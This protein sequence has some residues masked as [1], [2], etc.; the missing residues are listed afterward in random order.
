MKRF[1][2]LLILIAILI[3]ASYS[4]DKERGEI[5]N[6]QLGNKN[7][8]LLVADERGEWEKGLM[9][10]KKLKTANGVIFIFPD[11][12]IRSFWNK[13]TLVDLDIYW[14]SDGKVVGKS[15]LPSIEKSKET[16]V[17]NS[18]EKV[19]RVIELIR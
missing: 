16:V 3:F 4:L 18:P 2:P 6:Y 10:V 19:N 14:I 8:K 11:K 9:Y 13:N 15:F 12:Q 17:V 5:I 7:L 1:I